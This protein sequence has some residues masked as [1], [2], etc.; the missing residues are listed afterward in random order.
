MAL[1]TPRRWWDG[2]WPQELATRRVPAAPVI[3]IA[4]V[5][6]VFTEGGVAVG[7]RF[8]YDTL[9]RGEACD[10]SGVGSEKQRR[11]HCTRTCCGY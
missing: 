1:D 9:S 5:W 4:S 7:G 10:I 6:T 11:Q 8:R 2:G 3:G